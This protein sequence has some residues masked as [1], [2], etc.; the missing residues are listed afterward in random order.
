MEEMTK[1]VDAADVE[2]AIDDEL[3]NHDSTPVSLKD[4]DRSDEK[5]RKILEGATNPSGLFN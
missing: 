3:G 1:G 2:A 5:L 4:D